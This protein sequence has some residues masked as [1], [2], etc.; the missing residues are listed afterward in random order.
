[1]ECSDGSPH[2]THAEPIQ[3]IIKRG[4]KDRV[5]VMDY[6]PVWMVEGQKLAELLHFAAKCSYRGCLIYNPFE[7]MVGAAGLEPATSCV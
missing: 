2:G 6:E 3:N 5:A 7:I 1:M 4:G